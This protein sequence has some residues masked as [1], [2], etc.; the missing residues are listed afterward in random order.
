MNISPL[1]PSGDLAESTLVVNKHRTW[2]VQLTAQLSAERQVQMS[3][4]DTLESGRPAQEDRGKSSQ[5][6]HSSQG[7]EWRKKDLESKRI[8]HAVFSETR[9]THLRFWK[10][11]LM[12]SV[13]LVRLTK[14]K[15]S[16]WSF[17]A[18]GSN[19]LFQTCPKTVYFP[20]WEDAFPLP[21][22]TGVQTRPAQQHEE[23]ELGLKPRSQ[24]HSPRVYKE[25]TKIISHGWPL[26]LTP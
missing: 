15:S 5:Y 21:V 19:N 26:P 18:C 12:L 3:K 22:P 13:L 6:F 14:L 23:W 24:A 11:I 17:K 1:I 20:V 4:L 7:R 25:P 9:E 8:L 10:F 16:I 2:V